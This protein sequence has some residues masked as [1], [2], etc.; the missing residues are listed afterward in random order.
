MPLVWI[1]ILLIYAFFTKLA[2]RRKKCVLI[3]LAMVLFFGN[4][5]IANEAMSLWEKETIPVKSIENYSTAIVLTGITNTE[6]ES[7]DDRV[8]FQKGADRLLHTVQLYKEGR[9]KNILIS[10]GSGKVFGGGVLESTQL[11]K[12]FSYCGIPDSTLFI[13]S[14]SR[15]TRENAVYSKKTIDSLNLKGPFLLIT[16]AF[17]MRRAED[18]FKKV[19][20]EFTSY[21]VDI[22]TTDRSFKI[23]RLLIPSESAFYKW[24]I[25]IHEV[26]G[27][28]VYKVVGYC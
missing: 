12:V 18:C 7:V 23:N 16:S 3:A 8:F 25:L 10:G 5:F 15:N 2:T 28:V 27:Y 22:H 24:A 13:E 9:I 19:E 11:K 20:V 26:I 4:E 17:H 6:K 21:P 14:E 1:T